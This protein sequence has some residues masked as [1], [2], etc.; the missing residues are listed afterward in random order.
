MNEP[1]EY[2]VIEDAVMLMQAPPPSIL[3]GSGEEYSFKVPANG[4][5]WRVEVEQAAFHPGNSQPSLSVEGCANNVPFTTGFVTQFPQNDNDPWVDIDCDQNVGSYDPNDK[6]GMPRG[7]DAAH[8]I[9]QNTDIEYTIRFQN[10]GTDTAFT[11]VI[12]DELSPWLDAA[13]IRPGAASH[14]YS[15]DFY[16]ERSIKFTFENINLPDSNVNL[17][18]SQGF[19]SFRISQKADVPLQTDI[20]NSAGI[21]FDFNAPV[22]TNQTRH[23]VAKDFVTVGAW[24]PFS[25]G[26]DLRVM[27]NPV[28]ETAIFQLDGLRANTEWQVELSDAAGRPVRKATVA[29]SRWTFERGALP[30]GMYFLRIVAGGQ[31]LGTGKVVLK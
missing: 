15:F 7:Y 2:V 18:G 28:A 22:I 31:V 25:P 17:A 19:V 21:Y 20:L 13:T 8:Y 1:L 30:S 26:L 5:T 3:L 12:R 11:V 23:R 9:E 4:S 16:D 27:P 24:Q 6:Q 10:T 14:P 29:G